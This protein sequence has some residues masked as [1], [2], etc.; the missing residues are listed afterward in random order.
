MEINYNFNQGTLVLIYR[1]LYNSIYDINKEGDFRMMKN[2]NNNS[3][4]KV[5]KD[6]GIKQYWHV[7]LMS[8]LLQNEEDINDFL[9]RFYDGEYIPSMMKYQEH[10]REI[11]QLTMEQFKEMSEI[12][13]RKA[14]EKV[15]QESISNEMLNTMNSNMSAVEAHKR[16]MQQPSSSFLSIIRST[17]V[18][19]SN[20]SDDFLLQF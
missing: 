14:L 3:V 18:A 15:F 12:D 13:E 19:E 11:N 2:T 8:Y 20:Y 1:L 17:D 16:L 6:L 4:Q 7:K 10:K 9:F 5:I